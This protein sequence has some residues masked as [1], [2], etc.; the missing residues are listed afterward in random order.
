MDHPGC[1]PGIVP[2][3]FCPRVVLGFSR[4]SCQLLSDLLGTDVQDTD[5]YCMLTRT[6]SS[7]CTTVFLTTLT[8]SYNQVLPYPIIRVEVGL[9][10]I[11]FDPGLPTPPL[12][13]PRSSI[14]RIPKVKPNNQTKN[15]SPFHPFSQDHICILLSTSS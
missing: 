6:V 2:K 12:T 5:R 14:P 11:S 8:P 4:P 9:P 3:R 7:W 10:I 1:V 15:D 13:G